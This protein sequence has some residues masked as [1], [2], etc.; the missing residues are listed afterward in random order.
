MTLLCTSDDVMDRPAVKAVPVDTIDADAID[1][2]IEEASILIEG[3]LGH[4]YPDPPTD[5]DVPNPDP[6]P[7]AA[8]IVCARVVARALT[9]GRVEPNFDSYT[10]AAAMGGM[11]Y[12]N[13]RHV[14]QDVLG[15]GVWLTRQDKMALD[16]IGGIYS[17]QS[18][19]ALYD[20]PRHP[21]GFVGA[22][23]GRRIQ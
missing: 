5:I 22:L 3:Y 13:T 15:G 6:V 12:T 16:S 9:A 4:T 10:N 7:D 14:A 20:A 11:S 19:V 21:T 18:N 1:G 2:Y 17:K 8:R 23:F